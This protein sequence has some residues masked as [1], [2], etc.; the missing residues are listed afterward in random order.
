MSRNVYQLELL[1]KLAQMSPKVRIEMKL[2]SNSNQGGIIYF[3]L[4]VQMKAPF[5]HLPAVLPHNYK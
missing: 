4:D 1:H 5:E 3:M 2:N